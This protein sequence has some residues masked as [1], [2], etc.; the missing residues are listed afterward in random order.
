M[1]VNFAEAV[2]ISAQ[3]NKNK[4]GLPPSFLYH[5]FYLCESQ[6]ARKTEQ[7][8]S[9]TRKARLFRGEFTWRKRPRKNVSL[10]TYCAA[11][12]PF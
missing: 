11:D 6:E 9:K 2:F 1:V 4:R 3:E 12:S 10:T 7:D 5:E 8:A